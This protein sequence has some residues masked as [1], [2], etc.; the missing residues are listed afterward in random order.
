MTTETEV[1]FEDG[2]IVVID[3][4]LR[5]MIDGMSERGLR[6]LAQKFQIDLI[7]EPGNKEKLDH[8]FG[9]KLMKYMKRRG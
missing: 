6:S 4:E 5:K 1:F 7:S 2:T 9:W 8:E 3:D